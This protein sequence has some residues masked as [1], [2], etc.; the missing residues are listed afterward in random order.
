MAIVA[1]ARVTG[2]PVKH[3][4][5]AIGIESP[6]GMTRTF[7]E[8]ADGTGLGEGSGAVVLKPLEKAIA[9]GDQ[10][11]AVILGSAVNHDGDRG[12]LTSPDAAAQA[13]LLTAAWQDAGIDPATLGYIE[14]HGTATRVGDP[15]EFDGLRRAFARYTDRTQFCAAG[16]VKA[17]IGHLFEASGVL[18]I[19]KAAL[20]LW[21]RVI[22]P[23]AN[24]ACPNQKIDFASGPI[25]VPTRPEPWATSGPRRCGVSAFGLGGTNCHVVLEEYRG[26]GYPAGH[27]GAEY[28][29]TISAHTDAALR[30][31]VRRYIE[32]ID[33][34]RF[35]GHDLADICYTSNT[36]RTTHRC[37]LAL[38]VSSL[39][40]LRD[41]LAALLEDAVDGSALVYSTVEGW[42]TGPADDPRYEI[43]VSYVDGG[44]VD[45]EW[46]YPYRR[47]RIIHLPPY[48]FEEHRCWVDFPAH[49]RDRLAAPAMVAEAAARPA[50]HRIEFVPAEPLSTGQ[51][52][53]G[54]VL[55]LVDPSTKAEGVLRESLPQARILRLTDP[56]TSGEEDCERI[57]ELAVDGEYDRIV[58]ALGFEDRPATDVT[59]LDRRVRKNLYTLFL[60]AKALMGAGARLHLT[61]LTNT[62][63]AA[64]PGERVT[65]E[66]ATLVGLAK[67]IVREYPYL[68]TAVVDVDGA[69][70]AATLRQALA[71]GEPGITL[72]RGTQRYREVFEE[73]PKIDTSAH[74]DYLKP[75]GTYLITGGTGALGRAVARAFAVRQRGINVVLLSRSGLPAEAA[76]FDAE[77]AALG[78]Q[79]HV[80]QADAGDPEALT[81]AVK[82]VRWRFGRIDGIVHAAGIPGENLIA[83]RELAD[84]D[85]VVRPKVHGG[86]VLDQLTRDSR[87]DFIVHF[88]SVATVFPASGQ[89]DYAAANYYLDTVA[90]ANDDPGCHVLAVDWVAW[91]EIGMAVAYG[92][93]QD[94]TFKALP[95]DQALSILDEALRSRQQRVFAGEVNYDGDLAHV[96]STYDVALAAPVAQQIEAATQAREQQRQ[97]A[98]EQLRRVMDAVEVELTGRPEGGYSECEAAVARCWAD[99]F[100]YRSIDVDAD[101]FALGGDS[102]MAISLVN[103][104]ATYLDVQLDAAALLVERSVAGLARHIDQLRSAAGDEFAGEELVRDEFGDGAG[105]PS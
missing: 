77:L 11:Y 73:L 88:S 44:P 54:T 3:P 55:A 104:I 70:P 47:P 16:S 32:Y 83:F 19:I 59:E 84:F 38:G 56:A 37:R 64:V 18:G 45:T 8:R 86:F 94:T 17:N 35:A 96:L 9:D 36:T 85:A 93:N 50:T 99:A 46:L 20:T 22:P 89:G 97:A 31:L 10:I 100:G 49:W 41:L 67:T 5:T 39:P 60:L 48:E 13:D 1:G 74:P 27:S 43:A 66:N 57:A 25:R 65:A 40:E 105:W 15:I 61:V 2:A 95:T 33:T 21:H 69:V 79:V 52:T 75:G 80:L 30:G 62:A 58:F 101:F 23:L 53:V 92:T 51:T 91:K 98:A 12:G 90:R 34:G 7:D 76:G 71:S 26:S 42:R 63:V 87:P 81:E 102:I 103:N 24:F 28:L 29:F 4:H 14:V 82:Q 78:A 6:D 72:L 68:T